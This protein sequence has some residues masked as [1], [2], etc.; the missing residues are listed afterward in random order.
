MRA[1]L[2]Y[3]K[4]LL[5]KRLSY[6]VTEEIALLVLQTLKLSDMIKMEY[7]LRLKVNYFLRFFDNCFTHLERVHR[8]NTRQTQNKGYCYHSIGSESMRK[9]LHYSGLK[10]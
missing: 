7:A 5:A 2:F 10:L 9:R 4:G 6:S 3:P 1:C 8:C